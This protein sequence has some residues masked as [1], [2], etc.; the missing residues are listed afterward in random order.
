MSNSNLG[1]VE[2][3][4]RHGAKLANPQWAVSAIADDGAL[5]VSCWRHL[6]KPAGRGV[7]T[8]E[9]QLSRWS[10][11]EL[12]NALLRRHLERAV[13]DSLPVRVIV[14][15]AEDP[16]LVDRGSNASKT[17][18]TFHIPEFGGG[19]VTSFDGDRFVIEFQRSK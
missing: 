6:F 2:A 3:F 19:G 16:D 7:L 13:A 12:G 1:Y 14:A 15:T 18:K 9:D 8:Y 11:N 4:A 10:G 5:V 17:R